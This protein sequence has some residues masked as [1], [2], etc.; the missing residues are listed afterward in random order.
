MYSFEELWSVL[1]EQ[2]LSAWVLVRE[3][4]EEVVSIGGVEETREDLQGTFP[5]KGVLVFGVVVSHYLPQLG[6][7][8]GGEEVVEDAAD[9]EACLRVGVVVEEQDTVVGLS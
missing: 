8:L 5:D 1:E 9:D 7:R 4:L 2:L 3:L 6:V